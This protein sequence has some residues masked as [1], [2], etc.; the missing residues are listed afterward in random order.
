MDTALGLHELHGQKAGKANGGASDLDS[1]FVMFFNGGKKPLRYVRVYC[2]WCLGTLT[3]RG[4]SMHE[5]KFG[6]CDLGHTTYFSWTPVFQNLGDV[7]TA[8]SSAQDC[9]KIQL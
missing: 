8:T 6:L 3:E 4:E 9:Q 7:E 1:H 5:L 2:E